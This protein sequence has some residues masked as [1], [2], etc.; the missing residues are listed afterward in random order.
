VSHLEK[1]EVEVSDLSGVKEAIGAGADVIMLDN[2][3]I[4]RIKEAV[5][6]INGRALVEVSGGI[7]KH[8]LNPLAD[9]GV[10]IISVGALTHSARAVDISMRIEPIST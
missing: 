2:M 5:A 7:T 6:F 8:D 3:D 10:D 1:V 4:P 9:A